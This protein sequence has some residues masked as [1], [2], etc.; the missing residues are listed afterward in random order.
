MPIP[1]YQIL[2]LP[3]LRVLADQ[4]EHAVRDVVAALSDEFSLTADERRQR[5]QSGVLTMNNRGGLGACLS[6]QSRA[7]GDC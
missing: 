4:K 6:G 1:D 5:L 2:M 3:V 7:S